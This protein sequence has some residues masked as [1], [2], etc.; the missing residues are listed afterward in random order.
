VNSESGL[1]AGLLVG[2]QDVLP[3]AERPAVPAP[4]VEIQDALGFDGERRIAGKDPTAM[5]PRAEGVLAE[6]APQRGPADLGDQPLRDD[7]LLQL[8][9]RPACQRQP[10]LRGQLTREGFDGDD[11][12]GGKSGPAARPEAVPRGPAFGAARSVFSTC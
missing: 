10:A 12:S 7:R 8:A 11:D 1:D 5:P 4:G 9:Q 6:P 3:R 2:R